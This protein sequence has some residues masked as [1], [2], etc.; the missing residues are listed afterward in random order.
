MKHI[1]LLAVVLAIFVC[2]PNAN[3]KRKSKESKNPL[4]IV[5]K[6]S[7]SADYKK[8]TKDSQKQEGLF[9]TLYNAKEGKLYFEMPDSVFSK[10]YILANRIAATSN[11]RDFVA[12]QMATT[13]LLIKFSKDERRVYMHEIQSSELVSDSDPVKLS[14]DKNFYDPVI[15]GFK[16]VAEDKGNV[17]IDVTEFFGTN[18][19][20]ISPIKQDNPLSKLFGGGNSLKGTFVA[21]ASGIIS[22][23]AFP[24]NI[25]IKSR[26]S[27]TLSLMNEPYSVI[28]HRSLF[29]L[30]E[31]PMN[32]RLQD[33]RVGFFYSDKSIYTT[34]EDGV[35]V[36]TYIHRWRLE[37][38]EEDM[39]RYFAGEIVE[40]EKP[41][42]FYVD[43]AFPEKW[44]GSI[45]QGIEDWN[46]A[47][48]AAGFKNAIK[49]VDYPEND[50]TFDPDDMR[51][52]CFKYA[53]TA[54]PNAM[55]PSY[56]DPRTGEILTG[57]V[58]WYHNILSLLHNW[59]FVQTATV[60][61][62]VRTRVF[63]DETMNESIRYA[64]AHEIG[65][66]L[67]L[68]HNMGASYSYPVDSL[69]SASFTQKYGTTPSIMDYARNNFIAQPGDVEKGV[70][71]TPPI[72]GVYDIYAINW[73]YRLIPDAN[74]P[75]DE[76][77]TLDKWIA[78]KEGDAMF[79]FGAQQ[80]LGIVDPTDQTED[81]GDDHIK[82][83][84]YGIKNLKLL[85]EN[86][87]EWNKREGER[88]DNMEDMYKEVVTQY[89]RY[90]RHVI[91]YI[92]GIRYEEIRQG[93]GKAT[94]KHY[95]DKA[96]QK[97]A[98]EWLLNEARTH[99]EWLTRPD[100]I[101]KLEINLNAN[102][103]LQSTIISALINSAVLYRIQEG[104]IVDSKNNYTLDGYVK[105][106]TKAIFIAPK[107]GKLSDV[108]QNLQAT[109]IDLMIKTSGLN[110]S[111]GSAKSFA[112]VEENIENSG[113]TC[114]HCINEMKEFARINFGLP[115]LSAN[116]LGAIMTGRLND[117]L[118]LYKSR[119]A[120]ATGST[121]DF[122]NYQIIKIERIFDK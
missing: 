8:V 39:E 56:V 18:E 28:M 33:N 82:A 96:T 94:S 36:K 78:E 98:M 42:V 32:M 43:N 1:S 17:V 57:D 23:K 118:T 25:E 44:R 64:A 89:T 84:N 15:K 99:S 41:I 60:D 97:E 106:V 83:G 51:Y 49:A 59:R 67:G 7:V 115:T 86:L 47:F 101:N 50:S 103:K 113:I 109:A 66:T 120:S 119:V 77:A 112:E 53:A 122:Y 22:N 26:L 10:T 16:I 117:V 37:P 73:G 6:D 19:K 9:T 30:P 52:S 107:G 79:E 91:P 11:T 116:Q 45:K 35:E 76:K 12:G 100:I 72:L 62:K 2:M 81:L 31:E 38:K 80:F 93:D 87:E 21:D 104:G 13:P 48:E 54:T 4:E 27:F 85:I 20:C 58:I 70:K 24:N 88:Y 110:A 114:S 46:V 90:I 111:G 121:K 71:L 5:V 55:G 105:D 69:R 102:D 68:M 74:S 34:D 95:I 29:A 61:E 65:H 108:E 3:A 75:E 92:G 63:D 40:P 14:Y